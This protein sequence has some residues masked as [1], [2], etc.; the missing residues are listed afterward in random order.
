MTFQK[1]LALAVAGAL[2]L[3]SVAIAQDGS[4]P[5]PGRF[6]VTVGGAHVDPKSNTGD[7]AGG[8]F[9][10]SIDGG[11]AATLGLSYFFTDNLAVEL[12]GSP[13]KFNHTVSLNGQPGAE[14]RHQPIALSAQYHFNVSDQFRPFVGLGYH[15]T[16]VDGERGVGALDG[17]RVGVETGDGAIG[18]VGLD[19]LIGERFFVRTDLRYMQ[20]RSDVAVGGDVVGEARVDPWVYGLSVGARF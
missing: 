20:W 17:A 10:S 7:L 5:Q 15:H 6:A 19:Y 1:S 18:T 3:S 16:N 13:D 8:A 11:N 14:I 4:N 2:S 9:E 12:W